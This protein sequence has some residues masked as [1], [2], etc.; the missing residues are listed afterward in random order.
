VSLQKVDVYQQAP[1]VEVDFDGSYCC[2][3]GSHHALAVVH[4]LDHDCFVGS[5]T[6]VEKEMVAYLGRP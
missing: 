3:E 4:P 5:A 2:G 1:A 6:S